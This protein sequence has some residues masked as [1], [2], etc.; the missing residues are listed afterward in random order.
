MKCPACGHESFKE[1]EHQGVKVD[2]CHNCKGMWFDKAELSFYASTGQDIPNFDEVF[3][4]AKNT[5][6]QCPRCVDV[7]LLEMPYHPNEPLLIDYCDS[8]HGIFLDQ[9]EIV[10]LQSIAVK[11]KLVGIGNILNRLKDDGYVTL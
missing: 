4:S 10:Q 5:D 6:L 11:Y 3:K 8:C 9:K 7:K 2:F 1:Y